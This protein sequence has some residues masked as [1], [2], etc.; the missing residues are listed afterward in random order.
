MVAAATGIDANIAS[1]FQMATHHGRL[2]LAEI[3]CTSDSV[4]AAKV[5]DQ[6]GEAKRYSSAYASCAELGWRL[7]VY[8]G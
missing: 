7:R 6:G 2:D 4:I 5:K 8:H 3:C 1:D